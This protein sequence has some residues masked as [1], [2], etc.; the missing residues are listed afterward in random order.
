MAFCQDP[1]RIHGCCKLQVLID[2]EADAYDYEYTLYDVVNHAQVREG[3]A[4]D[5]RMITKLPPG[6]QVRV[7]EVAEFLVRFGP[8]ALRHA[9]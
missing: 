7:L 5:S 1:L 6:Q 4:K 9:A 8:L 2:T 3:R